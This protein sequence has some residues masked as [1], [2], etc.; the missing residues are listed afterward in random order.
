M[1]RAPRGPFAC[2]ARKKKASRR[3]LLNWLRGKDLNLRPLGY[4]PN[5]LPGCSTP[6]RKAHLIERL[7]LRQARAAAALP[8]APGPCDPTF[9][10]RPRRNTCPRETRA[11][12]SRDPP[13]SASPRTAGSTRPYYED[14]WLRQG[15][16]ELSRVRTPLA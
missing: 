15:E 3:R 4:E 13:T 8:R 14:R 5:E 11:A 6:R 10:G 2:L 1:Q 9:R 12:R 7:F 16:F